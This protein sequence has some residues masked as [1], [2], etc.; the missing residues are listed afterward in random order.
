MVIDI[1]SEGND[2]TADEGEEA[3]LGISLFI[4]FRKGSIHIISLRTLKERLECTHLCILP[5]HPKY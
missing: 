3:Q 1:D 2:E 4:W 5:A